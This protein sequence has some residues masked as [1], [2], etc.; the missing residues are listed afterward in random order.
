MEV[1]KGRSVASFNRVNGGAHGQI[2]RDQG[3][4]KARPFSR[5]NSA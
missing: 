2:V 4:A 5:S 1:S 3:E